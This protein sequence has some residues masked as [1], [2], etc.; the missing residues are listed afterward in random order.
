MSSLKKELLLKIGCS[1]QVDYHLKATSII[2]QIDPIVSHRN[3]ML[4]FFCRLDRYVFGTLALF[5]QPRS[6]LAVS[7][8]QRIVENGEA[9]VRRNDIVDERNARRSQRLRNR[10]NMA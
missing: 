1:W 10:L 5:Q 9:Q 4:S 6:K 3:Q 2:G 7:D 8:V